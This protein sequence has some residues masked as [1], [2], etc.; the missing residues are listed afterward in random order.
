MKKLLL[1]TC[2]IACLSYTHKR[3]TANGFTPVIFY[4][5]PQTESKLEYLNRLKYIQEFANKNNLSII[6]PEY[7]KSEF[8]KPIAPWLDKKS[9]KYISDKNRFRRKRCE[10][11]YQLRIEK[12]VSEAKKRQI[13]HFS[14][15][16]LTSPYQDH[17]FIDFFASEL[18]KKNQIDFYY[19]DWRKGYWQGRNFAKNQ[20]FNIPSFCGCSFSIVEKMLE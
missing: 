10:F 4:Y 5:N 6:I 2:C 18:S 9:I 8:D 11:C 16:L 17:E 12:T 13:K 20:K 19:E 15:T 3:L 14:T 7:E 1:H